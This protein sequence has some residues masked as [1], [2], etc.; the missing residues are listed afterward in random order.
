LP[1]RRK[2][3]KSK[4]R[5]SSVGPKPSSRFSHHGD[6]V[7]SGCALTTTFLLCSSW[8]RASV[9]AKAGIS[10]LNAVVGFEPS[11]VSFWVNVPWIAVPFDVIS[12][13]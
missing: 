7:W 3:Q 13:T 6:P 9:S 8:E 12:L 4:S 2:S 11:K 1:A 5:N 10:V